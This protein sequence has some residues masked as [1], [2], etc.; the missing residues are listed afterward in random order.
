MEN[1]A[2]TQTDDTKHNIEEVLVGGAA[3]VVLLFG[4][5]ESASLLAPILL[6]IFIS[7]ISAPAIL[8]LE[9]KRIP[10]VLAFGMVLAVVIAF[11]FGIGVLINSTVGQ[12]MD[13][14]QFYQDRLTKTTQPL[15]KWLA[16]HKIDISSTKFAQSFSLSSIMGWVGGM[17]GNI[18]ALLS[19]ALLTFLT[20]AFILFETTSFPR[21][22]ESITG[23]YGG[24]NKNTAQ[25]V[26]GKINRYLAIKTGTS[27]TTGIIVGVAL[28]ATGVR[29]PL[30]WG[31]LAFLLNFI[32]TIGSIIAAI[33]AVLLALVENGFGT[34]IWVACLYT[35]VN[36]LIGNVVE[37]RLMGKGL[38]LSPLV[39]FL[40]L[41]F[42]GGILG[43]VGMF[44]AV[45]L[46]MTAKIICDSRKDTKWIG[47]LLG[48]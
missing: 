28:W 9:S 39:V 41:I 44:L 38:G 21:K 36:M 7:V 14:L 22:V 27:L 15:L 18:G 37:P 47:V 31:L 6:A 12:F 11:L 35:G 19:N 25:E 40:S 4:L 5:H 16:A 1:L 34:A 46:T 17:I 3:V 10:R 33:P 42:W 23:A 26:S 20:V 29:F 13:S 45:P 30:L 48:P 2:D 43:A 24:G 8:W 32:P